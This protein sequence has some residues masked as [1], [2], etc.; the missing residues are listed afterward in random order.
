[1]SEF[2]RLAQSLWAKKRS[3]DGQWLYLP[4]VVHLK[5]CENTIS[6]LFNHWLSDGQ[7]RQLSEA[8]SEADMQKLVKFL[9]F[10]H[11][12]G[13]ASAAFQTKPAYNGDE[14]LDQLLIERLVQ[15]GFKSFDGIRLHHRDQSPHALAGEA[16][17]ESFGVNKT[18]GAIIGAHH[19]KPASK[20]PNDQIKYY[21]ANYYQSDNDTDIQAPWRQVQRE[22]VEYGLHTAGY[23]DVTEIPTL[24]QP[25]AV[26][27]T[28]LLIMADWLASSEFM[29]GDRTKPLFPLIKTTQ[30]MT[31][32]DLQARFQ[33]AITTW[34]LDD[35]WIPAQV[36]QMSDPYQVRFG[37]HA[38][39]V[40]AAITR[41]LDA[42]TDPGMAIIEAPMGI[43]KTE[44]ALIAVEQLARITGRDGLYMGLPTQATTSAMFARVNDWLKR[45]AA[46][47]TVH[48]SIEELQGKSPFD[49]VYTSLPKASNINATEEAA[50]AVT[51]ND[52]FSGKKSIL[53]KFV[54][55][56][57]DNL[58]LMGLKQKHLFLRH[59][60]F[61]D[62]VVVIDEAHAYDEFMDAYLVR[63]VE[64]LGAYHVPVVIL[65]ATL[66]K[67]KRNRLLTAYLEGKY[68]ENYKKLMVAPPDWEDTQAYPLLS[69]LDGGKLK[70]L[71][72]FEGQS[73]QIPV[74][75]DVQR[76]NQDDQTLIT[77]LLQQ[78]SEGGVAGVIVNTVK[79]A[80]ALA[81]LIPNDVPLMVLHSAFLAPDRARQE[82]ELQ[83]AI[84]KDGKRPAKLIVIGTQV[85]EQSLDIDF[86]I[87]YTD[88]AP[89]DLILQRAGRLQRH[90][91]IQRPRGFQRPQLKIMSINGF[92]DYENHT[93]DIYSK[94]LLM[95]T[96]YFLK[97]HIQLPDDISK[98]V[99]QVYD[100]T[101]D[102]QVP[103]IAEAKASFVNK[104]EQ[105]QYKASQYQVDKPALQQGQSIID[106]LKRRHTSVA[107]DQQVAAAVRDIQ[108][109]LEV[110]LLQHTDEGDFL[111]DGRSL[112]K[113]S[114]KEIA[115]QT[116][117]LPAAVTENVNKT[118][119][120]LEKMTWPYHAQ[121]QD[122]VWLRGALV[123]PLDQDLNARLDKWHLSYS[124]QAGLSYSEEE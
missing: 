58:L 38:R 29:D 113:V 39:P 82:A 46:D 63:A 15:N 50:A 78:L 44:I 116:L 21:T 59:L 106:W 75:L 1:M 56:T 20:V 68:G 110:I 105:K 118:V 5:D 122:D 11:D 91:T 109:T 99:Q 31:T 114:S 24:N 45:V 53:T 87:L 6:W 10:T 89:M 76:I 8:T 64:W 42:T 123:L 98:L 71:T 79:R 30:S 16:I 80:Q 28:G 36:D 94:Y 40:Q 9:G 35:E 72:H 25:E 103:D 73:D 3:D 112:D 43:G 18:V 119:Q 102:A 47:Q 97:S 85:L 17:L 49:R 7:R 19:G 111:L 104:V 120:Q 33:R 124:A 26:I 37:F 66:P 107:T 121:W 23:R 81:A 52:W 96:D 95:K 55:G 32:I 51:V 108:E 13:K 65:S 67:I 60:G 48:L 115:Q 62:K 27:L 86:D 12:V 84:G 74:T 77:A 88:I 70:Q 69:V 90:Q 101:T 83:A 92:G 22:L 61:S 54:V 93:E 117:R 41:A 14:Q 57:I 4:L 2:S 34:Q 100:T